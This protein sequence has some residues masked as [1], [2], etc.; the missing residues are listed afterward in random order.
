MAQKRLRFEVKAAM[1]QLAAACFWFWD[2]FYS[3]LDSAGVPQSI[4]ARYPKESHSKYQVMRNVLTDLEEAGR[5]ETLNALISS[6]YRLSNAID[7]DHLDET[8]AKALLDDFRRVVG[9]D[10]I[11]AELRRRRQEEKR[12][13]TKGK[14]E[15]AAKFQEQLGLLNDQF[16]DLSRAQEYSP[17]QRS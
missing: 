12:R 6:F 4:Y 3:F 1:V 10:P 7:R 5:G 14:F 13:E 16:I 17:Q 9:T 15:E 2:G 11:D 8:R